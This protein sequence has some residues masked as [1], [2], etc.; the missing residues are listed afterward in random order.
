VIWVP[1]QVFENSVSSRGEDPK[2]KSPLRF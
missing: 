2:G 1:I